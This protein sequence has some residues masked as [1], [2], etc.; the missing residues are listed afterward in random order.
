[1]GTADVNEMIVKR[2]TSTKTNEEF[3]NGI[4]TVLM[5]KEKNNYD[6]MYK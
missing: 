5:A 3:I 4:N 6:T 2:L 1:M